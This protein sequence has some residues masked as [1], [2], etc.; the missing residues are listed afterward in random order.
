MRSTISRR[1]S[2]SS[3]KQSTFRRYT[4]EKGKAIS[5]SVSV[6]KGPLSS[7]KFVMASSLEKS[8]VDFESSPQGPNDLEQYIGCAKD[9]VEVA[10]NGQIENYYG[11]E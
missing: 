11:S 3:I 9:Q 2:S 7:E 5:S 1:L 6:T 4:L 10:K 8:T